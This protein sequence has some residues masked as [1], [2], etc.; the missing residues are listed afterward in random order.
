M[1]SCVGQKFEHALS[2]CSSP[3]QKRLSLQYRRNN[4]FCA[5]AQNTFFS[6]RAKVSACSTINAFIYLEG[7]LETLEKERKLAKKV[8][9]KLHFTSRSMELKNG[10]KQ[11]RDERTQEDYRKSAKIRSRCLALFLHSFISAL[12]LSFFSSIDIK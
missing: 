6:P 1:C 12:F 5:I 8:F 11:G 10:Q 7:D 9:L 3:T 4:A 2:A